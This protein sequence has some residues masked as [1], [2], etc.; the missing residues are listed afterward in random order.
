MTDSLVTKQPLG[1]NFTGLWTATG[2]ANLSDGLYL[3]A[4]PLIALQ[5]THSPAQ[6][7]GVTVALT[8]AW[9]LFGFYA[10]LV[11]DRSDRRR[12]VVAVNLVRA[13]TL[14][15]LTVSLLTGSATIV[16]VYLAAFVLGLA[17]TLVD[18]SLAALVPQTVTR[19]A[20]LG[21]AN[22]RIEVAQNVTNQF[23]GPPLG[24]VLAIAGLAWVTGVGAALYAAALAVLGLLKGQFRAESTP[25]PGPREA[26]RTQVTAG[27]R[28][29]WRDRLLRNLTVITAA[30]NVFWAA[31]AAVLVVYLVAPGPGG[32]NTAGYGLLLTTMAI[33]GILGASLLGPLRR[34]LSAYRLLVLDVIG[35]VLLV[36]TPAMTTNPFLIGAAMVV[37]GA[38]SAVWR[39]I[40]T[41]IRQSVV[42]GAVLGRVYSASRVIS[43]GV[44]PV[45]AALGGLVA[46]LLGVRAVFAIGGVASASLLVVFA[47][48][49]RA[50]DVDSALRAEPREE[51]AGTAA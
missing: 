48:T 23:V 38:G 9:P 32:L 1:R 45:G 28:F 19:A 40:V 3:L 18:T 46:E 31:W 51:L 30:M 34:R 50:S 13:L 20:E 4:L 42:P 24:G 33:G 15:G 36:G 39:V 16:Q 41:Q 17:E 49:I 35:T 5:I 22:A 2:L 11:V 21:R 26:L 43:W 10:G 14:A 25:E 37:G 8:L 27:L 7:A 47:F 29:I 44:L 12:L 6:V